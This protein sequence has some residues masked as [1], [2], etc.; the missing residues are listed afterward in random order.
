MNKQTLIKFIAGNASESESSEVLLWL[1][2]SEANRTYFCELKNLWVMQNLPT[3]EA[4]EE[5]LED[6]RNRGYYSK[7]RRRF[8][9]LGI[10]AAIL[11]VP[12]LA[13]NIFFFVTRN[14]GV[15]L[16]PN[17]KMAM[18][19]FSTNKGVKGKIVLPDGSTVWLNSDSKISFPQKFSGDIREVH[20][21]GEG[22][23][24]VSKDPKHPMIITTDKGVEVK[25]LGTEFNLSS[26]SNDAT[27]KATL[28]EGKITLSTP[29]STNGADEEV[30]IKPME[31]V[32]V[33]LNNAISVQPK[34]DT[35]SCSAWRRGNIIFDNEQM[36]DVI[37]R[38]ERWHGV[39]F[40]VKNK[41]IL[42][43]RFTAQFK[44]ESIVQ[45]MEIMAF[46]SPITY[47]IKDNVVTLD[48]RK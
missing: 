16:M 2:K 6:L 34:A 21:T 5:D 30:S 24:K 35:A 7:P 8:S 33:S 38:L 26:Y 28:Y 32:T 19:S 25:V 41:A 1:D 12:M 29:N 42:T 4:S 39:E 27:L 10:A 22:Y 13:L 14:R 47:S 9:R 37:K 31:T 3:S 43:Y 48:L 36:A 45:I 23:F 46:C 11:L 15:V 44:S 40:V 20:F 18:A 17:Q